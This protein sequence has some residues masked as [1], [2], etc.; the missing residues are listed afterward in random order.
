MKILRRLVLVILCIV[1]I[2]GAIA[3][4]LSTERIRP[5]IQSALEA[6]LNR[7]VQIGAVHLN[8]FRGPGFTV[9][10]VV[11][12]DDPSAGIEP[13]A[14]V[15]SMRA[16]VRLTSLLAGKLAFS[17]LYLDAPSMNLVRTAAGGWNVQALLDRPA[18]AQPVA[19]AIPDIQISGGRLN[20]KFGDTKSVFHIRDADLEIFPNEHGDLVIRFAGVPARTD[21]GS[22]TFGQVSARGLL[23]AN[24]TGPEQLTMGLH[25]EHTAISEMVHLFDTR[26]LGVHGYAIAEAQLAGPLDKIGITG[27]L[28]IND[29]HRWDLMP[30]HGEGWTLRYNGSLDLHNHRLNLETVAD[31]AQQHADAVAL[32]FALAD[33]L[34]KPAWNASIQFREL[35]AASLLETARHM[36]APL[37]PGVQVEGEVN[38]GIAY[39]N[40][41]GLGGELTLDS[42]SVKFPQAAVASFD[43]ARM[44]FTSNEVELDP[45]NVQLDNGQSAEIR[46]QFAF[47]SSHT[48]F[49]I[50]TAQLT[51]AEVEGDAKRMI[52]APP[53]P[54]LEHLRQGTWKGWI[55][56]D[57]RDDHPAIWSGVYDLQDTVL[58]I[59][60]L[61][62]P[63]RFAAASVEMKQGQIQISRMRARAG[64]LRLEGDYH[65]DPEAPVPHRLHLRIP[66]VKLAELELLMLPTLRR[67]EGFLARTFGRNPPL[68]KWLAERSVDASVQVASL[69]NGDSQ[70]GEF[71]VHIVWAGPKVTLS[72]ID[73]RLDSMHAEGDMTVSLAK[74]LPSYRITG[75]IENLEYRNGQLDV[76]GALET[77]GLGDSL[78]MNVQSDG[79]FDGR[80]IALSTDAQVHEIS[81]TYRIAPASGIPRLSLSNLQVA[82]G[83]DNLVGQGS[84][85]ADGRIILELMSGRKP[86]RLTGML[87]P[88]HPER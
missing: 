47:D 73:L 8:L 10:R 26:D 81:G 51:I 28:N 4:R 82:M 29:I 65:Y 59:P 16:R 84:S 62:S 2:A 42:A 49:R 30:P 3:P 41:T 76:E 83:P 58:D 45:V 12:A 31:P 66:E 87:L 27:S 67:S 79:T 17:S 32:R 24:G 34:S 6:A 23:H 72:G 38:G 11:I 64:S 44:K 63:V 68:P 37:A 46:G 85:S 33:Y 60:G 50:N 55:A 71:R 19:S 35:P 80:E 21:R 57:R 52:E 54:M 61:A 86:V 15:E 40:Q 13:F 14:Y 43:S 18:V 48:S 56:F 7:P 9:E 39:S 69:L 36:G 53:I 70:L 74:L 20:F 25:L 78:L 5:R 1:L 22:Q 88:V 77:S 75:N